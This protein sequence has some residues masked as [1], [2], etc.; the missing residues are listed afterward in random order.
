[1]HLAVTVHAHC[2]VLLGNEIFAVSQT[3]QHGVSHINAQLY[4]ISQAQSSFNFFAFKPLFLDSYFVFSGCRGVGNK[5]VQ[6]GGGTKQCKN[7]LSV[8]TLPSWR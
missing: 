4:K 7:V 2:V 1:M 3:A 8:I 6:T 5:R